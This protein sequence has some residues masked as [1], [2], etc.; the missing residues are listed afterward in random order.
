MGS[1][2]ATTLVLAG[3]DVLL[4]EFN[5]QFLDVSI[6]GCTV[7]LH[8]TR[9]E[10][11]PPS[12]CTSCWMLRCCSFQRGVQRCGLVVKGSVA[13]VLAGVD[14]LLKEVNQQFLDANA[15]FWRMMFVC[16]SI[17][18]WGSSER[19]LHIMPNLDSVL[20]RPAC[21]H[22]GSH[23]QIFPWTVAVVSLAFL[24]VLLGILSGLARIFHN[25][26]IVVRFTYMHTPEVYHQPFSSLV[27]FVLLFCRRVA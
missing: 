15:V 5:Q 16:S 25:L 18:G 4:K 1:G 2:I 21:I 27:V 7:T 19:V 20:T 10:T 26:A 9:C 6:T 22:T 17:M 13:L 23:A 3:V 8:G 24:L 12:C 11:E 14:V